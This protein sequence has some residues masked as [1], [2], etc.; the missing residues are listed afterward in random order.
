MCCCCFFKSSVPV[1]LTTPRRPKSVAQLQHGARSSDAERAAAEPQIRSPGRGRRRGPAGRRPR[2]PVHA[3]TRE[4][5]AGGR[6]VQAARPPAQVRQSRVGGARR[7]PRVR[8]QVRG[9]AG[10]V[11]V[12]VRV[13]VSVMY[14]Y[15]RN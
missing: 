4:G 11:S 2:V 9:P 14:L 1:S 8:P 3:E 5:G 6:R 15:L 10:S 12:C 7:V 13:R